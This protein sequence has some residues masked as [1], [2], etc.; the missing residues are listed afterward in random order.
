MDSG[1]F[2]PVQKA[3]VQ[4]LSL[5]N[6]WFEEL[7]RHYSTRRDMVLDITSR[8]GC[9]AGMDQ[10]G[11]FIWSEIPG[12]RSGAV[13]FSDSVLEEFRIFITPGTVF[14]TNGARHIRISLCT[15]TDKLMEC[16]RRIN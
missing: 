12:D 2:F 9:I 13:E 14:G 16:L 8:L 5:G 15:T 10:N 4:A 11:M 1:M 3:A 7:N 6:A